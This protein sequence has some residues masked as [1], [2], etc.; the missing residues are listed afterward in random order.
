MEA[1]STA[2]SLD[3]AN[4]RVPTV[5]SS[6]AVFLLQCYH[7]QKRPAMMVGSAGTA[8][9]VTA[10]MFFDEMAK[11]AAAAE[12]GGGGGKGGGGGGGEVTKAHS[13][14]RVNFSSATTAGQFQQTVEGELDKRGGKNFGPPGGKRMTLFLD[15]VS[16]PEINGYIYI[17]IYIN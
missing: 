7:R 10:L 8:K 9:T 3:F 4:L 2:S 12:G 16:M 11:A 14:K 17:Y 15:D 1:S 6:R 5:D 13:V